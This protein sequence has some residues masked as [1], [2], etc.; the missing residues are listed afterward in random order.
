MNLGEAG[1]EDGRSI[2]RAEDSAK[3]RSSASVVLNLRGLLP[4]S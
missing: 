2:L 1:C 3:W 4:L